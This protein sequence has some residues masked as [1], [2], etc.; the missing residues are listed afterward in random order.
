MTIKMND[1][2]FSSIHTDIF[3]RDHQ[4]RL[5]IKAEKGNIL[6]DFLSNSV[7]IYNSAT[8][9]REIYSKF[10]KDFNLNYIDEIKNFISSCNGEDKVMTSLGE[11]IKTM[12][13][14][15]AAK[16]SQQSGKVEKIED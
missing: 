12:N 1:G 3:G 11:G 16:M 7:S 8:L 6:L 9:C 2:S 10:P 13:L 4:K 5:E 15:L 14:I